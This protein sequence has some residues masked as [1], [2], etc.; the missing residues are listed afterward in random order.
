MHR[1]PE[2][3]EEGYGEEDVQEEEDGVTP[4]DELDGR[5]LEDDTLSLNLFGFVS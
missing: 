4:W 3:E 5:D 1:L 2:G